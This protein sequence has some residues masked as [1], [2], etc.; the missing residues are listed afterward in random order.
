MRYQIEIANRITRGRVVGTDYVVT[1]RPDGFTA[2]LSTHA[3]R[4]DAEA[5][6]TARLT[7]WVQS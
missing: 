2:I 3:T 1:R 6:I 5:W 4:A 7:A